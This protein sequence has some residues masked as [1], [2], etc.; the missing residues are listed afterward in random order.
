MRGRV[1]VLEGLDGAGKTTLSRLLAA[2]LSAK[3]LTTPDFSLRCA[4]PRIDEVYR[5]APEAA[6]L[7]YASSVAYASVV[8][9]RESESGRDVVIDRYWLSTWAYASAR[10]ATL[11]LVEVEKALRAADWTFLVVVDASARRE[12]LRLRADATEGDRQSLDLAIA[13]DLER[14]Y[15][16]ALS[17]PVAGRSHVLDAG[18]SADACVDEMITVISGVSSGDRRTA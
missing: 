12:R 18:K 10:G 9:E 5:D 7:F 11:R 6:H 8:A 13:A 2:R 3:L 1:I 16:E 15:R 4:R 14:R 17:F